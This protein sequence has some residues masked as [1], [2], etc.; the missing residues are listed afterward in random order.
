MQFGR[1]FATRLVRGY[2]MSQIKTRTKQ[3]AK[4]AQT[5]SA[6]LPNAQSKLTI[7]DASAQSGLSLNDAQIG[8]HFLLSEYRGHLSATDSGELLFQFPYGFSKPWEKKDKLLAVFNKFKKGFLGMAKFMVRA[9]ISV[10]LIGYVAVFAA[11][12]IGLTFAKNNE[13]DN[14]SSL[15]GT[16]LFHTLFRLIL[17][18]LF[19]TFHPFS[20]FRVQSHSGFGHRRNRRKEKNDKFYEKV[21]KFVFGPEQAMEDPLA[22]K[23]LIIAEI[24]AKEGRIGLADVMRVTG[25]ERD[26]ADPLMSRLMLDYDGDVKV[27]DDGGVTYEFAELRKTTQDYTSASPES[28]WFKAKK[29]LPLTGN[30]AGSN[31]LIGGLNF[32][33]MVMSWAA[34]RNSWTIEKLRFMFTVPAEAIELGMAFPPPDSTPIVLGWVPF[35]FSIALLAFPLGR[36]LLR[37]NEKRKIQRENGRRGLLKGVLTKLTS[38]GID[39]ASLQELFKYHAGRNPTSKELVQEVVKLGG[40]LDVSEDGSTSY[41][42]RDLE[43]EL[44]ALKDERAKAKESEKNIGQVVFSSAN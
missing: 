22:A 43:A 6:T 41:R 19:W 18:S 20:P 33:N 9:W 25:L 13:R 42:F 7:A 44:L 2:Q 17:D 14:G 12:L 28:I 16:L 32:F 5:L 37:N 36:L 26:A 34:I 15:G 39:E 8:L 24:R 27:S 3:A 4:L 21:N 31:F 23:K 40:E 29:L 35:C 38:K 10:V 30:P 11:I 1:I